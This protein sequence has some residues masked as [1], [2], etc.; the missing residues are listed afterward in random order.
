MFDRDSDNYSEILVN[1]MITIGKMSH[2]K[3]VFKILDFEKIC[4]VKLIGFHK[5]TKNIS[6][7]SPRTQL[8]ELIGETNKTKTLRT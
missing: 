2:S 6:Q 1:L 8:S 4:L 3:H 7:Y 5:T